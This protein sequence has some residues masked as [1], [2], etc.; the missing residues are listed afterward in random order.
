MGGERAMLFRNGTHVIDTMLFFA[1]SEPVWLTA[2]FDPL[3][4]G[5]GPVYKGDGGHNPASEP[6]ALAMIG[7][8]N[9]VRA[10]YNGSK[11]TVNNLEIEIQ[12]ERGRI[13]IGNQAADLTT[14]AASGGLTTQ[15]LPMTFDMASGMVSAINTLISLIETDGDGV[16]ALREARTTLEILFGILVSADRDGRKLSLSGAT[17]ASG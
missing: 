4:A 11:R 13:R 15:P 12:G 2:E 9:G 1:E 16:I 3:D 8:E 10:V 7:F 5:Y 6:G 17:L 14:L